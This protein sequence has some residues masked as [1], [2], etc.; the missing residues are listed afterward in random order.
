ME[1][2]GESLLQQE[3]LTEKDNIQKENQQSDEPFTSADAT[4]DNLKL[5]KEDCNDD[6]I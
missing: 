3:D 1:K 4:A 2:E 5:I 6:L